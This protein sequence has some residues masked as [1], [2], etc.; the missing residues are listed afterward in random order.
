MGE[1]VVRGNHNCVAMSLLDETYRRSLDEPEAFWADAAAAIDW[2]EPW[3]RVLDDSRA[4]LYRW[5]TG[6]RLN[7]CYN[8]LDRHVESGRADQPALIYD[9]PV[10]DTVFTYTYR[11][12]RDAVARFAGALRAQGV[13]QGDRVIVYMPMVPEAVIAMLAC[14]RLGAVHSV[15][16][17]GFAAN[18]LATRIQDAKPKVIVSASCGIEPGRLVEY[19]PLLDAAIDAVESKPE[20]S[21]V[22]QRPMLE[23]G[24]APGRDVEWND[25]LSAAEPAACV[26]VAA[27]DPL[28]IIYTSGTTGQPK[29]IVRDNGGH[30]V[31]LAWSM[32][33]IYDVDQ[34]EVYWAASDI[35]WTVGH[36]YTVYAPLFHGCTT[37]LYEGKP[38]GTPDAGAFWRVIE[39][40]AV[41]TLFTAPTA[42]RAI[43][44]QDPD[45]EHI[46]RYDRSSLRAL[47]LAGER[48]DP[49]TLRW[50]EEQLGVPVIDHYWQTE[51]GWPVVAN[52]IGIERLPVVPGSPT[53]PVPGWD[54]RVLDRDGSECAAGEIAAL[55]FKLPLPPGS[56]PTL[57]NADERFRETYLSTFPGYYQSADAGFIDEDGYVFVMARTDD[58][59]NVAGH[60]LSTGAIEEVLAAH[61]DVAECAVIGVADELKGQIPVGLLVLKAGVERDRAEI[62]DET[63]RLVRDRIG[64]VAVFKQAVVVD[65][66]PK[67]RSG[68]ILRG[69]MRRIA[70]AEAYTTPAT[71]DDPA[72]LQEITVAL[73]RIGY[74][75]VLTSVERQ[76]VSGPGG[77]QTGR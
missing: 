41:C 22:L 67:T 66:L 43:R 21:I 50:A 52:C 36:S 54:L 31:A 47:F 58:I 35:G 27:T 38:V 26:S 3:Q 53:K 17:G 49:D 51:T 6:G 9:S 34:G 40:H 5:F 19:K 69:T 13:E 55:V 61:P 76:P 74:A 56:S 42:F 1:V 14:A 73:E 23:A 32:K 25:A 60:R 15:V 63:V 39:Q 18:E 59:I 70:D 72:I 75:A 7:T 8:A 48:C 57:W 20:R 12:L 68:K 46:D 77:A 30:A 44:Q 45:G 71:I 24:L 29:G 28:Y 33:N 4:P 65:R 37:V 11:E 64:P 2:D 62:C 10:T 16:F